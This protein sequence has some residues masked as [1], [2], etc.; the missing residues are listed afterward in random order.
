M[1]GEVCAS[2]PVSCDNHTVAPGR[3]TRVELCGV[4]RGR[5]GLRREAVL[6][7]LARRFRTR[8]VLHLFPAHLLDALGGEV[9]QLRAL[10]GLE[11][12]R[13]PVPKIEVRDCLLVTLDD[14]EDAVLF[15]VVLERSSAGDPVSAASD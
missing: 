2:K 6:A 13:E 15:H 8:R 3:L 7:L 14:F 1:E 5:L 11:P 12:F 9:S 10:V 4:S